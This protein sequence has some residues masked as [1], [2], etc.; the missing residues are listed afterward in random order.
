MDDNNSSDMNTA[1]KIVY[2]IHKGTKP[3]CNILTVNDCNPNCCS[4]WEKK[5]YC[6]VCWKSCFLKIHRIKDI[7]LKWLQIRIV[8]RIIATNVVL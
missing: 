4:K 7:K 1:L 5:S 3:Y 8:H 2:S 6:D